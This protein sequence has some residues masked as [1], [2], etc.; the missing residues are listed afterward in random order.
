MN[1]IFSLLIIIAVTGCGEAKQ[2][3]D[4]KETKQADIFPV[5]SFID[6]QV[7]VVDSFQLP[8]VKYVTINGKTDSS[9]ISINEFKE[10]AKEFTHPD[11]NDPALSKQYK[12]TNFADQ[13]I[14]GVTFNYTTDNRD[15]ELQRVDVIIGASA[16]A[17]DKVR[18]IYMQKQ[19]SVKDTFITKK[20]YWGT[21]KNFQIITG[22][23]VGTQPENISVVKVEWDK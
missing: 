12:E 8:T 2:P 13:T 18:S 14:N 19:S 16:V 3:A 5:T 21:D 4:K 11:I 23:Q 17:N 20:L 22:K 10:L 15:L 9:L 7:H 6:G 1:K